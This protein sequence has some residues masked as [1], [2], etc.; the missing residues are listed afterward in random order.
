[1]SSNRNSND[2]VGV[3]AIIVYLFQTHIALL[4]VLLFVFDL[5]R[6]PLMMHPNISRISMS[7]SLNLLPPGR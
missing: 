2:Y 7:I 6:S 3:S 1:M 5:Y 4:N